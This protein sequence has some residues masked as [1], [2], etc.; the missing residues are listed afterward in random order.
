MVIVV[1]QMRADYI[2]RFR[3]RWHGGLRRLV[4]QGAWLSNA[5]YPYTVTETCPGHATVSTGVFPATHGIVANTWWDRQDSVRVT[6]TEDSSVRKVSMNGVATATGDSAVR[7]LAP[8]LAEQ[9]RGSISG[10]RIVTLSVKARS[11]AM[12]AGPSRRCGSLAR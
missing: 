3:S 8:S 10:S 5:A 11:A 4:D 7:L 12:L 1:D 2:E 9:L 6:C